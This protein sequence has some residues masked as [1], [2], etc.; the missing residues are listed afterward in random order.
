VLYQPR[1]W[2]KKPKGKG[3]SRGEGGK[4]AR[5]FGGGRKRGGEKHSGEAIMLTFRTREGRFWGKRGFSSPGR[6]EQGK[7][8]RHK[9]E[10]LSWDRL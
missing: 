10:P 9:K 8:R 1:G 4:N 2:R 3:V 7:G 5:T 6:K